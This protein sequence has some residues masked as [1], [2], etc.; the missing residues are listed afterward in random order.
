[1]SSWACCISDCGALCSIAYQLVVERSVRLGGHRAERDHL[2]QALDEIRDRLLAEIAWRRPPANLLNFGYSDSVEKTKRCCIR[3]PTTPRW[4]A[5]KRERRGPQSRKYS[6]SRT[7]ASRPAPSTRIIQRSRSDF[8]TDFHTDADR[9]RKRGQHQRP[10]GDHEPGVDLL[11]LGDV[12][13]L[14]ASSSRFCVG[15]SVF[16]YRP[17]FGHG[18]R[19]QRCGASSCMHA[20]EIV[21][22]RPHHRAEHQRRIRKPTRIDSGTPTKNTCICGIR[23]DSTPSPILNTRPNTRNGAESWIPIL[24]AAAKARVAMRRHRR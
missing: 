19:P 8:A 15:S 21:E 13:A 4:T 5:S 14:E 24:N 18:A 7:S 10:A 20:A 23:R 1:M 17:F 12:A 3:L 16:S 22:E 11:A 6:R 2:E 9:A